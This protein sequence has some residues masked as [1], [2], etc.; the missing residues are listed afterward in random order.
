MDLQPETQ[1]LNAGSTPSLASSFNPELILVPDLVPGLTADL[2]SC[3]LQDVQLP[4]QKRS[5][6]EIMTGNTNPEGL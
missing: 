5:Y 2:L 6:S 4:E 3:S 1:A